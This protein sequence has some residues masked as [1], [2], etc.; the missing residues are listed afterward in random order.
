MCPWGTKHDEPALPVCLTNPNSDFSRTSPPIDIILWGDRQ[1]GTFLMP[2]GRSPVDTQMWY[3][4]VK[5][6]NNVVER[7]TRSVEQRLALLT[8]S[9][10]SWSVLQTALG[11]SFMCVAPITI[12]DSRDNGAR[13]SRNKVGDADTMAEATSPVFSLKSTWLKTSELMSSHVFRP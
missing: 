7:V 9:S 13:R 8:C 1:P 4:P 2:S 10:N 6:K 5:T 3:S 12:T 11:R